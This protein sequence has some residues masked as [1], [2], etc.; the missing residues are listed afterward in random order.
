[1]VLSRVFI[2]ELLVWSD[3]TSINLTKLREDRRLVSMWKYCLM[4]CNSTSRSRG[5]TRWTKDVAMIDRERGIWAW[6]HS[7]SPGL[8]QQVISF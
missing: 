3:S 6:L 5:R 7:S 1:M 4:L 2:C 8:S